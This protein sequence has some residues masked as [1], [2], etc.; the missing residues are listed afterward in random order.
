MDKEKKQQLLELRVANQMRKKIIENMESRIRNKNEAIEK[1]EQKLNQIQSIQLPCKIAPVEIKEQYIFRETFEGNWA[2]AIIIRAFAEGGAV[3]GDAYF[4][5]RA[6]MR[7]RTGKD[8][9]LCIME[10]SRHSNCLLIS[11]NEQV[12]YIMR[13]LRIICWF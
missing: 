12:V 9:Q 4:R 6:D 7:E 8:I 3:R 13:G 5:I 2:Q 11:S 1:Q 10:Q